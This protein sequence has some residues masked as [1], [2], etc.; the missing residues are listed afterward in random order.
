M[1]D[2]GAFWLSLT[3]LRERIDAVAPGI[4]V[5]IVAIDGPGGAG[6][7]TL[8]TRLAEVLDGAPIVH[9]D[10]FASW[11]VPLDWWPRLLEQVLEPLAAGASARYQRYDWSTEQLA[12]WVELPVTRWMV[13][14]GVSASRA[15]FRPFLS[16]AIWVE[17][18]R[19]LRLARGLARDGDDELERWQQ[20]MADEDAYIEREQPA[21][22]VD[23]VVAGDAPHERVARHAHDGEV[24]VLRERMR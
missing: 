7:T 15:A 13:L 18:P 21:E 2:D 22:H 14:E 20:W 8:A 16:Y 3:D 5:R 17:T 19:A 12:D 4:P 24:L 10:D 1:S 23:V 11:D 9:T 6:K